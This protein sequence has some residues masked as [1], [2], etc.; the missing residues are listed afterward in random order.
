[1]VK[2]TEIHKIHLQGAK[3]KFNINPDIVASS[4]SRFENL[5]NISKV[6]G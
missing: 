6:I 3:K 5:V 2:H 1:M 4:F